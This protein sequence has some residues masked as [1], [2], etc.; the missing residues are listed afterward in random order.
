MDIIYFFVNKE[1]LV[2]IVNYFNGY[3]GMWK[4]LPISLATRVQAVFLSFY[5]SCDFL[6]G[7]RH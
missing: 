1:I 7:R 6:N 2:L 3:C 5:F 4:L